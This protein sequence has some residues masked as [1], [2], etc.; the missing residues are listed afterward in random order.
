MVPIT[1]DTKQLESE[2]FD[3][4]NEERHKHGLPK[5]NV[6][7][8][9]ELIAKEWSN[10]LAENRKL[11][12][13]DFSQRIGSIGYSYYSRGE[14]IALHDSWSF[15]LAQDFVDMWIKSPKHY[16]I[17]MTASHGFMGVGVSK[18]ILGVFYGVVDFRFN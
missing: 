10:E 8:K 7:S 6:D 17:M 3:L 11:T 14:I 2:I 16:E 4:I 12:H 9:L 5:L 1:T 13:G 15:N 18:N